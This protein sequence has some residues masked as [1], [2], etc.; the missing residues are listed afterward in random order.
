M[1]YRISCDVGGTFTDFALVDEQNNLH[2]HKVPSTPEDPVSAILKGVEELAKRF[3]MSSEEFIS[4]T[5]MFLHGTTIATNAV[6]QRKTVKTGFIT[7]K[8][9]E[10]I[11]SFRV[12]SKEEAYNPRLEEPKPFIPRYLTLGVTEDEEESLNEDEVR[13][14]IRTLKGYKVEAVGVCLLRS[15]LDPSHEKKIAEIVS[16]EWPEVAKAVSCEIQPTVGECYRVHATALNASLI[17]IMKKYLV[18]LHEKLRSQGLKR[19]VLTATS[20]AGVVYAREAANKPVFTIGSGPSIAPLT[21]LFYGEKAGWRNVIVTDMGGTSFDVS[22]VTN[23]EI[24]MAQQGWVAGYPTGISSVEIMSLGAGGGSIAWLDPG[25]MLKV[26]PQ[27]AGAVPGPV[28][29]NQGGREPTVTDANVLLGY[30][31][32]DYFLGG[33]KK[34]SLPMAEEAIKDTIANPLNLDTLDAAHGIF[35]ITNQNMVAGI[36]EIS[37]A[38]GIDPRHY[39]LVAAGGAGPIHAGR[40]AQTLGMKSVLI[41]R[42]AGTFCALG[43]ANS[44][45]KRSSAWSF[46]TRSDEGDLHRVNQMFEERE[47]KIIR[48]LEGDGIARDNIRLERWV[49]ARYPLQIWVEVRN[50]LP[51]GTLSE[52]DILQMVNSF[53]KKYESIYTY[54]MPD[55]PVEFVT[56]GVTGVGLIPRVTLREQPSRGENPSV[57]KKGERMVYFYEEKSRVKTTIYDGA[58]L[59]N[60]MKIG[61]PGIIEDP[62]TT[63]VIFPQSQVTVSEYGNYSMTIS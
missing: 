24:K 47:A 41:P 8:H 5:D 12:W 52:K 39:L 27:S 43:L 18:Q 4:K 2:T 40:L 60:G 21:G 30:L 61:G 17:P 20:T 14:A 22:M 15:Y 46:I 7:H 62:F 28:C 54:C 63:I 55:S 33:R 50:P 19:E 49:E 48:E 26:G 11:F 13:E 6:T 36:E 9:F 53:H 29:Y 16:E 45:I 51:S 59:T 58:T 23:G 37:I 35:S 31:N 44:D 25:K 34:L 10:D 56:W 1:S 57:A 42:S 32:P 3:S 38:R